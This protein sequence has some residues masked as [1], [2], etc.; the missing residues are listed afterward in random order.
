[1]FY[2]APLMAEQAGN[3]GNQIGGALK[4]WSENLNRLIS[5]IFLTIH[6]R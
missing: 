3:H 4:K 6:A 1:M 2:E 5:C